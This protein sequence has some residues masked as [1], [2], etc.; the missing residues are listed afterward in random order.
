VVVENMLRKL[1]V[2]F[3]KGTKIIR[4]ASDDSKPVTESAILV[5]RFN[6]R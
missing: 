3:Y 2:I 1:D 4:L 6:F 5:K